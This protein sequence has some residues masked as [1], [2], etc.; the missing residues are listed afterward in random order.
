MFPGVQLLSP[1]LR[2]A[3]QGSFFCSRLKGSAFFYLLTSSSS[4]ILPTSSILLRDLHP[5]MRFLPRREV[6][7]EAVFFLHL[8]ESSNKMIFFPLFWKIHS[9]LRFI[10]LCTMAL[11]LLNPL[12]FPKKENMWRGSIWKRIYCAY[13]TCETEGN[14]V[15]EQFSHHSFP[16]RRRQDCYVSQPENSSTFCFFRIQREEQQG[17]EETTRKHIFVS[18]ELNC[19]T[20]LLN[21][22]SFIIYLPSVFTS[23]CWSFLFLLWVSVTISYAAVTLWDNRRSAQPQSDFLRY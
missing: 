5:K 16:A 22:S 1:A 7:N 18:S 14:G 3:I 20:F 13:R 21:M 12:L 6:Q 2:F 9:I 17:E 10:R 15:N 11:A 8:K 23:P 19:L 4:S